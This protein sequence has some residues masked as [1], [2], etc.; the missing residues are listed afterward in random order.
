VINQ[1]RLLCNVQKIDVEIYKYK[2]ELDALYKKR[3]ETL[4]KLREREE[5]IAKMNDKIK[6]LENQKNK[7]E[8]EIKVEKT[9]LKKWEARF[10]ESKN[11]REG[12]ALMHEIEV[13]K[14]ALDEM[15]EDVLKKMEEIDSFKKLIKEE[16]AILNTIKE[17]LAKE[18]EEIKSKAEDINKNINKLLETRKNEIKDIKPEILAEYD[19]IKEKRNGLAI[20]PIVNGNCAGCH[21]GIHP[22]LFTK[23]YAAISI[24]TCP[25]CH[26]MIYIE[27]L[28]EC[29]TTE[30]KESN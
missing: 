28:L 18:E 8:E 13:L 30:S 20:V 14:K 23:V 6:E 16:E 2:N 15:E 21:M 4:E 25:S 17:Q 24:E 5:S 3:D 29:D 9:N 11:S 27:D 22:Q 1:I 10:N 26:R 12:I 19:K 7:T